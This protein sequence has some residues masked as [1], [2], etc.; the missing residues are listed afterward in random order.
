MSNADQL[1]KFLFDNC[2]IRGEIV[3]LKNSYYKVLENNP[4]PPAMRKLLGE[5][6]AV[7]GLLSS[8]LKMDGKISVQAQ[9]KGP[10]LAVMAECTHHNEVRAIIRRNPDIELTEDYALH[11]NFRDLLGDGVLVIT[12]EPKRSE[13]FA[14]KQERYQGIVPMDA[15]TFSACIEHYFEQSEQL[16]TRIWLTVNEQSVHGLMLQALPQ[17]IASTDFNQE[18]WQTLVT[19]AETLQPEEIAQLNHLEILYR[20]Y[21]EQQLRVYDPRELH[22][23]CSCS[24]ER[25]IQALAA[26]GKNEL[27][28]ILAEKGSIN[29]DCQFCNQHYHFT[30]EKVRQLYQG[31]LH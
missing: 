22:F 4:Y 17:Q 6:L 24:E 2:D 1:H 28:D 31:V 18:Q 21:H 14:G 8:T 12:I 9:G 27:E 13:N 23:A 11:G 20:L 16:A 19:L 10:V 29:M 3:S 26:L 25:C 7:V 5:F 15:D 30:A